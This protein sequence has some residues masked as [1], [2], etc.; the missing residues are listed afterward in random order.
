MTMLKSTYMMTGMR[1]PQVSLL[2]PRQVLEAT[3]R[4]YHS[5]TKSLRTASFHRRL[6]VGNLQL[7]LN[8]L[9]E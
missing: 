5:A 7:L 6:R 3:W 1:H 9:M 2:A 4:R 8:S